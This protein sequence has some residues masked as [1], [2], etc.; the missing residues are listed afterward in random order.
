MT[1]ETIFSDIDPRQ[2][3]ELVYLEILRYLDKCD[4]DD[5]VTITVNKN[6]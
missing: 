3:K 6:V 1:Y 4:P 2:D 5:R